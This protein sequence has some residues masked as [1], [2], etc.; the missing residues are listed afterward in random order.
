MRPPAPVCFVISFDP[1]ICAAKS[2]ACWGL[3]WERTER[4]ELADVS[5]CL[6]STY[7]S[8]IWTPP[9]RPVLNLPFPR[10]PAR[11]WALITSLFVPI[12]GKLG[13]YNNRSWVFEATKVVGG[14]ES[15]LGCFGSNT[16]WRWYTIL[17]L[18][19]Q[20]CEYRQRRSQLTEFRRSIDWYSWMERNRLWL[21]TAAWSSVKNCWLREAREHTRERIPAVRMVESISM[22]RNSTNVNGRV[23]LSQQG[24]AGAQAELFFCQV[25]KWWWRLP[26]GFASC[27]SLS[28]LSEIAA[29]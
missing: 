2:L 22:E 25:P 12:A 1:I 28:A 3:V 16:L 13:E 4:T 26:P 19:D 7:F 23:A 18:K 17:C 10:P 14:I 9:C 11:T 15:L 27:L 6:K 8:T 29:G 5:C 24:A 20:D 21:T